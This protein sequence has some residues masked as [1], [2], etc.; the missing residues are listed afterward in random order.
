M[1]ARLRLQF[2]PLFFGISE[3]SA[4]SYLF[5]ARKNIVPHKRM[6]SQIKDCGK[7]FVRISFSSCG[8][9]TLDRENPSELCLTHS[10]DSRLMSFV[11]SYGLRFC[12]KERLNRFRFSRHH[13]GELIRAKFSCGRSQTKVWSGI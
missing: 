11:P 10:D 8:R 12:M 3:H 13:S 6:M 9:K 1:T 5:P 2:K 7:S 4:T